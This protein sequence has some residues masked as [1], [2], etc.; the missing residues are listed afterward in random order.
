MLTVEN[1]QASYGQA[2]VI[3]GLS[4]AVKAG[5]TLAMLGRNGAGKSTALK[6]IMGLVPRRSGRI[7][8]N[9]QPLDELS[10][11]EIAALG[12]GYVPEDRRIFTELTVA[13]NLEVGRRPPRRDAPAW[14]LNKVFDLFPNLR[15]LQGRRGSE[16]SGGEQ[17]MLAVARTLM[18]NP[19]L[20]LLDE[21]S[22]GLAPRIVQQMAASIRSL[23]G[24]GL[25]ILLAEQ[26]PG[27]AEVV[28]DR[29]FLIERGQLRAEG[30]VR[31]LLESSIS[32]PA[33]PTIR[34]DKDS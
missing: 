21:P 28:A 32:G 11:H 23:K 8:L 24:Q 29:A 22:E 26:N 27:F 30:D 3:F 7:C 33:S 4:F 16:I 15:E 12:L 14:N 6:S 10:S 2:Q 9:G 25:A 13:E 1:L 19:R 20:V 31:A 34:P 5:E 18:G 17:Q